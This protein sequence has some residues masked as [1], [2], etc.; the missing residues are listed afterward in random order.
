MHTH[1]SGHMGL[2]TLTRHALGAA[3]FPPSTQGY[4]RSPQG[5]GMQG[6]LDLL[7]AIGVLLQD[8]AEVF[9][10]FPLQDAQEVV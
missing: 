4:K 6:L 8:L 1:S 7:A 9:L 10:F 2:L 5:A 3:Y